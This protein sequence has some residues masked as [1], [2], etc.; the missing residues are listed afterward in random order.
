MAKVH[1][2]ISCRNPYIFAIKYFSREYFCKAKVQRYSRPNNNITHI[3]VPI[4]RPYKVSP[5]YTLQFLRQSPDKILKVKNTM[6]R[7]NQGHT[8]TLNSYNPEPM[9]LPRSV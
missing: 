3:Q 9:S 5:F 2:I 4:I 1:F 8:M 6:A 7:S